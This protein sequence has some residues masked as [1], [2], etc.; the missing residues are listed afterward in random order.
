M[1]AAQQRV[2]FETALRDSLP[3]D[4]L[5]PDEI[6]ALIQWLGSKDQ[7]FQ[8][9]STGG[10]FMPTMPAESIDQIWSHLAFVIEPE[11]VRNWFGRDGLETSV[12]PLVKCGGDGS[13]FA[14][15]KDG[16][17]DTFVFLGSEG[18]AFKVTSDVRQFIALITMGYFSLEDRSSMEAAPAQNYAEFFDDS[19]PEP[20]DVKQYVQSA[21]GITYPATGKSLLSTAADDPFA[22][23]VEAATANN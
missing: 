17:D 12:V 1:S 3:A 7:S 8:Y 11:L 18:D 16:Q 6:W 22:K 4:F 14:I 9:R 20:R 2:N 23:W 5:L 15:W 13:H 21:F 10:V 19:W